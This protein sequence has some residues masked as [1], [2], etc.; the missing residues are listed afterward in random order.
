MNEEVLI[1]W[2]KAHKLAEENPRLLCR[3]NGP[4]EATRI[5][6]V[7]GERMREC[8]AA[9]KELFQLD[10]FPLVNLFKESTANRTICSCRFS[11][12][13]EDYHPECSAKFREWFAYREALMTFIFEGY[14]RNTKHM[15][16]F[17]TKNRH[18]AVEIA[19]AVL[20]KLS[21]TEHVGDLLENL[22][23]EDYD[24]LE[25]DI[26]NVIEGEL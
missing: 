21:F 20:I 5:S 12:K 3:N 10:D 23:N 15:L 19:D 26:T 6:L 24:R 14:I 4:E 7:C 11:S 16:D 13:R 22:S 9:D 2:Y 25:E 18:K 1:R 17:P 8:A